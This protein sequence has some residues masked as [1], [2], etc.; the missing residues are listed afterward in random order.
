M[1]NKF[2]WWFFNPRH[3]NWKPQK[4]DKVFVCYDGK[5]GRRQVGIIIKRQPSTLTIKFHDNISEKD[6][7]FKVNRKRGNQYNGWAIHDDTL[8]DRLFGSN[9]CPGDYYSVHPHME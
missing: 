6:I 2:R 9:R 8:M 1:K 4:N 3:L 7:V 5:Y